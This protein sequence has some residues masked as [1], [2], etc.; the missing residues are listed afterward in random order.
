MSDRNL[1]PISSSNRP[2]P[3]LSYGLTRRILWFIG[4]IAIMSLMSFFFLSKRQQI[5]VFQTSETR[6][7]PL[8]E[9]F[10]EV[11]RHLLHYDA[12][13]KNTSIKYF[14]AAQHSHSQ[15]PFMVAFRIYVEKNIDMS[16]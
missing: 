15:C 5:T 13:E 2:K 10:Q 16:W 4:A 1:L 8:Y 7:P 9:G 3:G 11:E 6:K 14:W 12:Y